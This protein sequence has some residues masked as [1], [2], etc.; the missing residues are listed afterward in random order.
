MRPNSFFALVAET[1]R[2]SGSSP[3]IAMPLAI[4]AVLNRIVNFSA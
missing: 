3:L 2:V 1:D 4:L